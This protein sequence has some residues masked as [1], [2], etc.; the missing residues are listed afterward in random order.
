MCCQLTCHVVS[1][2]AVYDLHNPLQALNNLRHLHAATQKLVYLLVSQACL[3]THAA[4]PLSNPPWAGK[5]PFG[6]PAKGEL[7]MA[8][9]MAM[10]QPSQHTQG[11]ATLLNTLLTTYSLAAAAQSAIAKVMS[12]PSLEYILPSCISQACYAAEP[13]N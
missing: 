10:A 6:S 3:Q 11:P 2:P 7:L 5:A 13:P 4:P 9:V 12:C 8:V 1:A